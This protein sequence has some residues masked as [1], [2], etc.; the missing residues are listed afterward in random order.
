MYQ[1][2]E[3]AVDD[4]NLSMSCIRNHLC[5]PSD[6]KTSNSVEFGS[7]MATSD[8]FSK[9]KTQANANI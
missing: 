9:V 7:K 3:I 1:H 2:L 8:C 6:I 4:S 5:T